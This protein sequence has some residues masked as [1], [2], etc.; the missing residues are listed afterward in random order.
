M[1]GNAPESAK[2]CRELLEKFPQSSQAVEASYWL[3]VAAAD[4]MKSDEAQWQVDWLLGRLNPATRSLSDSEKRIFGQ[5]LCL[6][7]QLLGAAGKWQ[8][9]ATSLDGQKWP[10]GR[11]AVD[12]RLNFWR[13]EAALRL[14]NHSEARERFDD[15]A[16]KTVGIN[17]SWVPMVTLRRAQLAARR[18]EWQDVLNL[19]DEL[20]ERYPEFELAYECDYL[21]GRALAGRGKMSAARIAYE[22]VLEN[23]WAAGTETAAM[24]QWMIGESYFHQRNYEL[25]RAAYERV[26]ERHHFP[27]WQARAA[28]QAGK[29]AE[30]DD[31]WEA[32]TKYYADAAERWHD[33]KSARELNARLRWVQEQVV[34][35]QAALR[36]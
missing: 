36:R 10:S 31:N 22:H 7:C 24:A 12:A 1:S 23:D 26:I 28:L 33:S 34:Q 16:G 6:Q 17:E 13:A 3:A 27:E 19:V 15:L 30:L 14:G 9:I 25:A 21:R 20:D 32:A 29:C 2:Y 5:V 18:E 8:E 4:E 35:R 11:D